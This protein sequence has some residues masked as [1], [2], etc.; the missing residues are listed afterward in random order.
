MLSVPKAIQP[1]ATTVRAVGTAL[2]DVGAALLD[3]F[4]TTLRPLL[5][6]LPGGASHI[7]AIAPDGLVLHTVHR[8]RV[9]PPLRLAH[10]TRAPDAFHTGAVQLRLP[11]EIFL[12]R[13]LRLPDAGRSYLQ[14]IIAHRLE[15]LTPWRADQV[16]YAYGVVDGV[17]EDGTI[18][19]DLLATSVD[20][21]APFVARLAEAG[22]TATALGS[23]AEPLDAPLRFDLYSGRAQAA[24]GRLRGRI[25]RGFLILIAGL[26]AACLV[27]AVVAASAASEAEDVRQRLSALRAKLT[28][29]SGPGLSRERALIEGK[30]ADTA[31]IVLIDK[32]SRTLPDGTVLRELDVDPTRVR[33]VGRS[34]DA[35][36]LIARLEADAGLK[37]PR[38]AAP[39]TRDADRQDAFDLVA[40]RAGAPEATR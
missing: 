13:S 40:A 29:R 24:D 37:N 17:S 10:G 9:G 2:R 4:V 14:P 33:L 36:A 32:L 20:L 31:M 28:A 15:R 35:P 1:V 27:S 18:G 34:V 22:L 26:A 12:S 21:A 39:V 8:D 19:V 16:L 30:R 23:A 38:F 25:R 3:A 5:A 11:P 6:R 7:V